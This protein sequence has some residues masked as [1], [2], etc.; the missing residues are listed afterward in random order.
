MLLARGDEEEEEGLKRKAEEEE[1]SGSEAE[2]GLGR[3]EGEEARGSDR[4]EQISM[5]GFR[6]GCQ[7]MMG[8]RQNFSFLSSE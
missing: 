5:V 7:R 1:E 2:G 3:E 6:F 8:L 4:D